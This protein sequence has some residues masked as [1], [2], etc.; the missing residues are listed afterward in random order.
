MKNCKI[1]VSIKVVRTNGYL[2]D[3][4]ISEATL[5]TRADETV[6]SLRDVTMA[7]VAECQALAL[8]RLDSFVAEERLRVAREEA[9]KSERESQFV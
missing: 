5:I 7:R 8:G 9:T 2:D 1:E 4:A 3:T 6:E